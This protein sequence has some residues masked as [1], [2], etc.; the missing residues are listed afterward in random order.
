GYRFFQT[1][2]SYTNTAGVSPQYRLYQIARHKSIA[3]R[4][5]SGYLIRIV[6]FVSLSVSGCLADFSKL[7][8]A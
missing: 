7:N 4:L 2:A 5:K 8:Q 1:F 6:G 3:Y